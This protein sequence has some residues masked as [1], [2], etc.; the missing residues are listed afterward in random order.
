MMRI[1]VVTLIFF[2]II[3]PLDTHNHQATISFI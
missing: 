1:V 2:G 3:I